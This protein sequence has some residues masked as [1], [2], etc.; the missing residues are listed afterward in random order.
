MIDPYA[1]LG[2]TPASTPAEAKAAFRRLCLLVH[3]DRG[4]SD[5]DFKTVLCAY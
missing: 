5:D 3:P 1:L 2:V 4:G